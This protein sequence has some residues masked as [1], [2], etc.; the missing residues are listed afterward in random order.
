MAE[1]LDEGSITALERF[2]HLEDRIYRV[3]EMFKALKKETNYL[4]R[5]NIALKEELF[6]L[7]QEVE[8]NTQR[9]DQLQTEREEIKGRV[10]RVLNALSVLEITQ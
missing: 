4:R 9:M 5:E 7:K 8:S 2:S 3:M 10:K 1:L 6:K